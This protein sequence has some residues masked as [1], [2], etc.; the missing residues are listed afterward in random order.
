MLDVLLLLAVTEGLLERLNHERAGA[1]DDLHLGLA[2]LH[3]QL[4]RD[5]KSLPILAGG[6]GD[7]ITDLLR[8]KTER[9]NLRRKRTRRTDLAPG[10]ADEDLGDG[11]RVELGRHG[12][13]LGVL[14][15]R[16]KNLFASWRC[17]L[18]RSFEDAQSCAFPSLSSPQPP[19]GRKGGGA[20]KEI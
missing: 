10:G 20:K 6:L 2:V 11:G 15:P 4:D 9:T 1:R 18:A 12:G 3:D 14:V 17:C 8:R 5:A 13:A 19:E 7:V 16:E